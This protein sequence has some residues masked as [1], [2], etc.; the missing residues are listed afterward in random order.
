MLQKKLQIGKITKFNK[1]LA[2]K[3]ERFFELKLSS[4]DKFCTISS[5]SG[6]KYFALHKKLQ[7][8]AGYTLLFPET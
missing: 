3:F 2:E 7:L 1:I 8:P 6:I 4:S 5:Q